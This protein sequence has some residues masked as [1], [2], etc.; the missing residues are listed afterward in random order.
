MSRMIKRTSLICVSLLL[1]ACASTEV[2]TQGYYHAPQRAYTLPLFSN[3]FRGQV[4]LTEACDHVGASLTIWDA[5]N[6]F[7]RIDD[8]RINESPY[9]RIPPFA[10]DRTIAEIVYANYLRKIMPASD[11]IKVIKER[12]KVF[13]RVRG[14]EGLFAVDTLLMQPKDSPDRKDVDKHY[15]YGFLIFKE[16]DMAYV[17]Q[18]RMSVFQPDRMRAQLQILAHDL[19]IPAIPPQQRMVKAVDKMEAAVAHGVERVGHYAIGTQSP[20]TAGTCEWNGRHDD[21]DLL[22]PPALTPDTAAPASTVQP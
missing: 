19:I 2:Q 1:A 13:V 4:T 11:R 5:E 20:P 9:A 6:R 12:G 7:F 16:G 8:L 10:A 18:H 22:S 21:T 14:H 15:Y 3:T 17:L